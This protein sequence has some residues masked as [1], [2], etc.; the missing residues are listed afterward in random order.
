M[1]APKLDS[2]RTRLETV[3][4]LARLLERIER[5]PSG[6]SPDQYRALVLQ[7]RDALDVELPAEAVNAVL[8]AYP[9]AAEV[10]ENLHYAQSGLSRSSIERSVQ[11]EMAASQILAKV[12]ASSRGAAPKSD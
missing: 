8:S 10:Y 7:L 1:S 2:V 12:A 9:A 4:A 5:Q 3:I 11:S 6:A